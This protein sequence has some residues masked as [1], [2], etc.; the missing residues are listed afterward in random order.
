MPPDTG[1]WPSG[2]ICHGI[3]LF[4]AIHKLAGLSV[5]MTETGRN[6]RVRVNISLDNSIDVSLRDS[7]L[8]NS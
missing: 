3:D 4:H 8:P 1:I 2:S 7:P 5:W 6:F